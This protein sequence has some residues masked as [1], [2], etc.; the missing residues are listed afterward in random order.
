MRQ[1]CIYLMTCLVCEAKGEHSYYVGESARTPFDRGSEHL[2][3]MRRMAKES[4]LVEHFLEEHQ[5]QTPEFS[6]RI[7]GTPTSNLLRQSGEYQEMLKYSAMGTLLNRRGEWG[8]NLPPKLTLEDEETG[9]PK[10]SREQ[11][12]MGRLTCRPP[13]DP[14]KEKP[15]P[16]Q[17]LRSRERIRENWSP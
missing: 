6:M 12:Q 15:S 11:P 5:G 8:Q 2:S 16:S 3:A 1:G 13:Q 9:G 7:I 14:P 4:P 17:Y 10:R